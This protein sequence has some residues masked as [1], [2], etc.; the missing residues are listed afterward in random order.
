MSN[1]DSEFLIHT[2]RVA[3]YFRLRTLPFLLLLGLP[4][5]PI[6]SA[7]SERP[8][9]STLIAMTPLWIGW[10]VYFVYVVW[11]TKRKALVLRYWIERTTLRIDEGV[12]IRKRKSIPLDRVTDVVLVQGPFMRLTGIWSLQVQTAGS[13][14]QAPEGELHGVIDAERARDTIMS[15]RDAAV[16]AL[17]ARTDE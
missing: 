12:V 5:V 8:T 7:A 16:G 4:S 1:D 14:Q 11:I 15:A 10:I 3:R 2:L 17:S 6:I 9:P 13:N